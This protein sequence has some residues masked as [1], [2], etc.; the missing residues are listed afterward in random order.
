MGMRAVDLG[1]LYTYLK[2]FG[3]VY[4][5]CEAE[6]Q[7]IEKG[8]EEILNR[9]Y[10]REEAAAALQVMRN[11]RNAGRRRKNGLE[12]QEQVR[13]LSA[14]GKTIRDISAETGIP[15]STVQRLKRMSDGQV[16]H[17]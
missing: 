1:E 13:A 15:K 3:R 9:E 17:N 5:D 16:S 8:I 7:T 2:L 6:R 14:Q 4:T 10:S 11:P 12:A